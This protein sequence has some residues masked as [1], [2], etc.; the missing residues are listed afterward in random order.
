M[1]AVTYPLT[2]VVQTQKRT[3]DRLTE[4]VDELRRCNGSTMLVRDL[5]AQLYQLEKLTD[6]LSRLD[7]S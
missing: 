4:L 1:S 7:Q 5:E 2:W 3:Y 6:N